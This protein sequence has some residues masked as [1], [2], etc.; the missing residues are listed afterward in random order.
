[1]LGPV[2][3]ASTEEPPFSSKQIIGWKEVVHFP[4]W[5]LRS[6]LAKAD[7]GAL[8][9]ALDV[10]DI[11]RMPGDKVK[12]RVPLHRKDRDPG[13][14]IV[15]PILRG[16]RIRSSNGT[17]EERFII[18]TTL[19]IGSV[20]HEVDF[21]LVDRRKMICRVLLGRRAL[22][23]VFL[24]DSTVKYRHGARKKSRKTSVSRKNKPHSS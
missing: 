5:G 18:R 13:T 21:S 6:M 19:Q 9:S 23:G 15:A 16:S 20:R 24:V 10:A 12:F 2:S 22:A 11:R 14:E 4:D 7:T 3:T 17:T 1:M 8:G